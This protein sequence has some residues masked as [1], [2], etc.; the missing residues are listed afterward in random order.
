MSDQTTSQRHFEL[1]AREPFGSSFLLCLKDENDTLIAQFLLQTRF[2]RVLYVFHAAA[3]EEDTEEWRGFLSA[4]EL[5]ARCSAFSGT[6]KPLE[7][8]SVRQ[9]VHK[10]RKLI[11][12][13]F[14]AVGGA[15]QLIETERFVGY[16][17]VPDSL[18]LSP[19]GPIHWH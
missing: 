10:L 19:R 14:A 4:K 16:R 3:S 18:H 2:A 5:G 8:H 11:T 1:L 7:V 6:K 15:P 9:L 12:Q 17:T 13:K